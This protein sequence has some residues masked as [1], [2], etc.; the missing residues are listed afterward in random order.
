MAILRF[1]ALERVESRPTVVAHA[2]SNLVS[3]YY[4]TNVFGDDAMRA[5][6]TP[7][8]FERLQLS[9]EKGVK[10][11]KQVAD[12]VASAMKTWALVKVPHTIH[13]GSNHLLERLQKS[14]MLSLM[15]LEMEKY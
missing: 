7:D 2:P 5:T 9:I 1:R 15:W 3:E 12:A 4:G 11:D 8:I 13:T 10:I 14:M 6:L